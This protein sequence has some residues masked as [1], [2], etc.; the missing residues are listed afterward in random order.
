MPNN[1][2]FILGGEIPGD[3]KTLAY[4]GDAVC[5]LYIRQWL[6]GG[7]GH[8]R[9]LTERAAKYASAQGQARAAEAL[10]PML[11]QE[12]A[13]MYRRGRNAKCGA[14]PRNCDP[15]DYRK[16]TGFE[17]LMGWLYLHGK[18]ERLE[19]LLILAYQADTDV[20]E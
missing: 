15:V 20:P 18:R 4:I 5:S 1:R 12:E 7:G 16:A 17:A 11:T 14:V 2:Q 9:G 6:A 19:E 10:L 3:M 13:D 8:V